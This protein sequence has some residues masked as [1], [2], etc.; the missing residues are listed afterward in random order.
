MHERLARKNEIVVA[1]GDDN[2][3]KVAC[4]KR[5]YHYNVIESQNL[6]GRVLSSSERKD[7]FKKTKANGIVSVFYGD[8]SSK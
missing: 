2:A 6:C 8:V 5:M 3:S 7:L 4:V 1:R